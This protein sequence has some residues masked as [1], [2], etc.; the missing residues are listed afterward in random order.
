M[1]PT[2]LSVYNT[3]RN[4]PKWQSI[5]QIQDIIAFFAGFH[6]ILVIDFYQQKTQKNLKNTPGMR[7]QV[8]F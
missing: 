1:A 2:S 3:I 8:L 7:P 5:W 4:T 6:Y